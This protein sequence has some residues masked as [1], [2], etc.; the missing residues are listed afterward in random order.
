[1]TS[2][3]C[4]LVAGASA[5]K[6][7]Y[8]LVSELAADGIPGAVTCRVL[9]IAGQPYYRWLARP[10][11]SA[12]E[13]A[14]YRADAL[15]DAHPDDPEFGYR[16]GRGHLAWPGV[17]GQPRPCRPSG[18]CTS[19]PVATPASLCRHRLHLLVRRQRTSH[20]LSRFQADLAAQGGCGGPGDRW[21]RGSR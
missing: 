7:L 10:V 21:V 8:P 6:R 15:F 18:R 1:M 14:A 13:V 20:Q 16:P 2:G 17:H 11:T 12:E 3:G 9:N 19:P 5:G 4:L